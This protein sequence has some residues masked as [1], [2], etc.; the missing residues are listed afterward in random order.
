M[1]DKEAVSDLSRG[2]KVGFWK[3]YYDSLS[4]VLVVLIK[5][6]ISDLGSKR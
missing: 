5:S 4:A 3:G 2:L 1:K 6:E